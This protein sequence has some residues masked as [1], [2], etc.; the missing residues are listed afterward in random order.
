MMKTMGS[1]TSTIIFGPILVYKDKAHAYDHAAP[2]INL[3]YR[4]AEVI[5]QDAISKS[6]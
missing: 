4:P 2:V 3:P 1:I 5:Q 6:Q